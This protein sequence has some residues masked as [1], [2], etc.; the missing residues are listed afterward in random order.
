VTPPPAGFDLD[1]TLIDSRPAIMASFAGVAT[2]TGV[3]IDPAAVDRR[4]GIKLQD[5]LA[6]WFPPEQIEPAVAIYRRH[7]RTL[8]TELTSR[9]PGAGQAL[10]A[11]RAAG[12]RVVV[13]TAKQGLA[14][15]LSLDSTGLAAD[16]LFS[17]VH[18]PEKAAVLAAIGAG[19]YVGDTPADVAAAVTAGVTAVGVA[20]GSFTVADLRAA[21]A[22]HVLTSLTDFPALYRE[23]TG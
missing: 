15:Q 23:I 9:L 13:I 20:T 19:V 7:Y 21:G 22:A 1:M 2:D 11:V 14:A 6:Y 18:G 8:L 3:R 4:L 16:E 12:A 5:E 10:A 17:E